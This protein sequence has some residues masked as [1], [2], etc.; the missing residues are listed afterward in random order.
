MPGEP[1]ER[2]SIFK[3]ETLKE[4]RPYELKYQDRTVGGRILEVELTSGQM[5]H[6]W[7]ADNGQDY[8]CHGL[9]FGG[10][11]AP[12]GAV[13]P[14]GDHI[15]TIL[16]EHYEEIPEVQARAGDVLVWFG[17]DA[18]DV[19]HSA[20]LTDPAVSGGQ[21]LDDSARLQTKNGILPEV[22]MTLGS[23]IENHY[24]EWYRVYRRRE[25][26]SPLRG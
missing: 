20:I 7:R 15:A 18:N 24:G 13:S 5:V 3:W 1:T 26:G 22:N 11:A 25:A 21:S 9:T 16:R 17:A 10:G 2:A 12:G 6:V 4:I 8:F 14:F 19:I 23:L